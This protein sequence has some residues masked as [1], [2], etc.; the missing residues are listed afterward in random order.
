MSSTTPSS[1][2][3]ALA[4]G[5]PPRMDQIINATRSLFIRYGYRRTAMDDI[6]RE[7]GVAKATLY[8]HFSGK[9]DVFRAMVLRCRA[10]VNERCRAAEQLQ[11]PVAARITAL[12]DANYGT[13]LE[14]FGDASHMGELKALMAESAPEQ[15]AEIDTPF[16]TRLREMLEKAVA[17]GELAGGALSADAASRVIIHAAVGAKHA[18]ARSAQSFRAELDDIAAL[19]VAA[20]GARR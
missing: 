7:A 16:R 20:M 11:A 19:A 1:D 10:V 5:L 17:A 2:D 13:A 18:P 3:D 8:L 4:G 14:W 9:D 6:A 15:A 12:L